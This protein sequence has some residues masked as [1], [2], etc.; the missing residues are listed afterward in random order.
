MLLPRTTRD[1]GLSAW[2]SDERGITSPRAAE[3]HTAWEPVLPMTCELDALDRVG[4]EENHSLYACVHMHLN[5]E[6]PYGR[7]LTSLNPTCLNPNN[8]PM[9]ARSEILIGTDICVLEL[10]KSG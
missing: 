7:S 5:S 8:L 9:V 4:R 10:K 1:R 6:A 2:P 3:T